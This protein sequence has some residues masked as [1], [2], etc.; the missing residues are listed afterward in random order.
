MDAKA[1]ESFIREKARQN[2]QDFYG[3]RVVWSRHATIELVADN[4]TRRRV[5]QA[6]QTC[7]IIEDYPPLH[8]PLP[9]C[10][11]LA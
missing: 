9:D 3:A 2:E 5:E 6:L 11:V 10:L 1:K 7:E 4:L 8:R